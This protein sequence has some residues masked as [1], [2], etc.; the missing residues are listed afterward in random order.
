MPWLAGDGHGG[1]GRRASCLDV[2]CSGYL[3]SQTIGTEITD[4]LEVFINST[5]ASS[6]I[7]LPPANSE[8]AVQ[9]SPGN[10]TTELEVEIRD[11]NGNLVTDCYTTKLLR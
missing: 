5:E 9:G 3:V 1:P 6:I 8:I 11:G 2:D 10:E 4:T 7:I